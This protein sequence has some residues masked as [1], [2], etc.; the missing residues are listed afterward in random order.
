[1]LHLHLTPGYQLSVQVA[2]DLDVVAE[3]LGGVVPIEIMIGVWQHPQSRQPRSNLHQLNQS[4]TGQLQLLLPN[5][6]Q[7]LLCDVLSTG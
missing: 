7:D 6:L 2:R 1:M 4:S 3:N 5:I